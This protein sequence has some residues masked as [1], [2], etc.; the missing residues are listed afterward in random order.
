M[1]RDVDKAKLNMDDDYKVQELTQNVK[2]KLLKQIKSN[3]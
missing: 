1:S 3:L 2:I